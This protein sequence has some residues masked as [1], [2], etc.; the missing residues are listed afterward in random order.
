MLGVIK[1]REYETVLEDIR[2]Y[3]YREVQEIYDLLPASQWENYENLGLT[4]HREQLLLSQ[5]LR[6]LKDIFIERVI[7]RDQEDEDQ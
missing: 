5:A 6:N 1:Y 2:L 7:K 4:E 3:E